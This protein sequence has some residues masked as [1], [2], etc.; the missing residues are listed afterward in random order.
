MIDLLPESTILAV[1]IRDTAERWSEIRSVPAISR[2]L[3]RLLTGSGLDANDLPRLAGNAA[4]AALVPSADGRWF[5]PVVLLRPPHLAE[6]EEI[7][8]SVALPLGG[9]RSPALHRGRGALWVGPS[10][11]SDRLEQIARGDGTSPRQSVE[12]DEIGRRLPAGG[13]VRGWVNP[14]ALGTLLRR[15]VEGVHPVLIEILRSFATAELDTIRFIGFRRELTADGLVADAVIGFDAS[16]LPYEVARALRSSPQSSLLHPPSLPPGTLLA[17]SFGTEAD[18]CLAWLRYVAA[19][20]RRGPLRNLDFWMEE[21]WERTGLDLGRDLFGALGEQGWFFLMEGETSHT[22]RAVAIFET[23]DSGRIEETL[24]ELRAWL[25]EH[26]RGRT[27]GSV[28]PRTR[29]TSWNGR[30]LHG[31]TFWTPFAELPGPAFLVTDGHLVAGTGERA[32]RAGLT[33]LKTKEAWLRAPDVASPAPAAL[34]ASA[35]ERGHPVASPVREHTRVV[36]P[37][38]ARWIEALLE[39]ASSGSGPP[40]LSAA[41]GLLTEIGTISMDVW[42]EEDAVRIRARVRFDAE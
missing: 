1:E 27:L 24:L 41:A 5:I 36:G 3:D 10:E 42:Y 14:G 23:Q 21:F 15:H 11:A 17:S 29:D 8:G 30:T 33:L 39:S 32:L 28:L 34:R 19:S 4:I 31:L 25:M 37:A 6:A 7:L 2:F 38:M 9:G 35:G 40:V 12:I 16:A 22:L 13:I 20:D 18:A 26:L